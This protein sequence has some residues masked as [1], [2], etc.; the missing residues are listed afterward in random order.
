MGNDAKRKKSKRNESA[1]K[2]RGGGGERNEVGCRSKIRKKR[3][4]N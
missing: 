3:K 4:K 2:R 1:W